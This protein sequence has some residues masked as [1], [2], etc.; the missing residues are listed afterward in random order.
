MRKIWGGVLAVSLAAVTLVVCFATGVL[1]PAT[2]KHVQ[3]AVIGEKAATSGA[4]ITVG[5][6]NGD[7][8]INNKDLGLLLKHVGGQSAQLDTI[9]ADV[10]GDGKIDDKDV[11]LMQRY[12]NGWGVQWTVELPSEGY[13]FPQKRIKVGDVSLDGNVVTIELKNVSAAWETDEETSYFEY[14]C[15][16]SEN[17]PI[18]VDTVKFGFIAVKKSKI[19]TFTIPWNTAKVALTDFDAEYWTTPV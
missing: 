2:K 3:I 4:A 8:K 14:T 10:N 11:G 9:A 15:Y 7:G 5:D 12:V 1:T 19:C 13:T 18:A 16:D 6:V 17:N